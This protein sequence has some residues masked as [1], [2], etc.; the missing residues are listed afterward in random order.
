MKTV[1]FILLSL[2]FISCSKD[3]DKIDPSQFI[4][5]YELKSCFTDTDFYSNAEGG[6]EIFKVG[7][8]IRISFYVD[9]NSNENVSFD[10]YF[11]GDQV[12]T[13][14]EENFG[15]IWEAS[16]G[17]Y[18]DQVDG[19]TYEFWKSSYINSGA[20]SSSGRCQAIT[21]KGTQCKRKASKGSIYCWQ[22]KNN[23]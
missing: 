19:T 14:D 20:S 22:H 18:I 15:R 11:D 4:G 5:D 21:Q 13:S 9:K 16:L 2:L 6:C 1:L 8:T 10:G 23:H 3:N 17:I 7:N 12:L